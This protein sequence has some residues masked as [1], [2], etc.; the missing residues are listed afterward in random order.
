M[1]KTAGLTEQV[2]LW[3]LKHAFK[4]LVEK[5]QSKNDTHLMIH[6]GAASIRQKTFPDQLA[7][8]L[9]TSG[10]HGSWLTLQIQEKVAHQHLLQITMLKRQLKAT[11][12]KISISRFTGNLE[13]LKILQHLQPDLVKLDGQFARQLERNNQDQLNNVIKLLN[14]FDTA[15]IMPQVENSKSLSKLWHL[16]V[17]YIQGNYLHPPMNSMSFEFNT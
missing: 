6:L 11:S 1:P 4:A 16:G 13:A 8:L 5:R 14:G 10:V 12:C 17:H 15:I 2:D 7:Q 3:V 9:E